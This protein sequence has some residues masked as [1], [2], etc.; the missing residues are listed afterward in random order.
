MRPAVSRRP[1][2]GNA[3]KLMAL[4]SMTLDHVGLYLL[5]NYLPLRIVGRLAFPL[6][7][8]MIAE[9]ARYT[10]SRGSYLLTIFALG[11]LCQVVLFLALGSLYQCI[12][13]TFS[14]SILLIYLCDWARERWE[15]PKA[16]V[17]VLAGLLG[18][19]LICKV[20]PILLPGFAVDY[21]YWGVL[22]PVVI[23]LGKQ[24]WGRLGLTALG[25]VLVCYDLGGVQWFSLLA[26]IPLALY[27]GK[28]G[29]LPLKY[30][31]YLYYPLHLLVIRLIA[32]VLL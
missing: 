16:R 3:I 2:S 10:R 15:Q 23:S 7:A 8:Y 11:M 25:L 18:A 1:L 14:L 12:L 27:S 13:I 24:H 32:W 19:G 22:L 31:F 6:F 9:G 4:V 5:G 20:L 26:L 30:F 28:R 21:G 29:R 17:A